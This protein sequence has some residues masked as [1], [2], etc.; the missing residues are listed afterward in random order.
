MLLIKRYLVFYANLRKEGL[1]YG[2]IPSGE[3][4]GLHGNEQSPFAKRELDA[5]GKR[6]LSQMLSLPETWDY[7][8]QGLS[9]INREKID[10][11]VKAEIGKCCAAS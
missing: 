3:K 4:Q 2:S 10:A 7:T 1:R 11:M 6:A 9:V 5:K 8:L